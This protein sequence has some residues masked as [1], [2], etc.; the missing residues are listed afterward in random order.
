[1]SELTQLGANLGLGSVSLCETSKIF[2]QSFQSFERVF[3]VAFVFK[4]S[5]FQ[6]EFLKVMEKFDGSLIQLSLLEVQNAHDAF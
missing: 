2:F 1:L 4:M 3:V 6:M 5:S